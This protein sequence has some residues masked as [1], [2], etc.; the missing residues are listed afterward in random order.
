M[1]IND[2]R[3]VTIRQIANSKTLDFFSKLS[4]LTVIISMAF[5]YIFYKEEVALVNSFNFSFWLG[6]IISF[7]FSSII[8][9]VI[10]CYYINKYSKKM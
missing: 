1:L 6:C 8:L 7:S 10:K 4:S 5:M 2:E 3:N 9:L